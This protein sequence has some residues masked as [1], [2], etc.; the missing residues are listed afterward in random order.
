MA[1]KGQKKKKG[2]QAG[3]KRLFIL[4]AGLFLTFSALIYV[5]RLPPKDII[6]HPSKDSSRKHTLTY[7]EEIKSPFEQKIKLIDLVI[8]T[9]LIESHI[10][11][12][13][14]AVTNI[15]HKVKRGR[16][17]FEQH[18]EIR[19]EKPKIATFLKIL[20]EKNKKLFLEKNI[21]IKIGLQQISVYIDNILTH[22]IWIYPKNKISEKTRHGNL[23]LIIDDMG[24]DYVAAQELI[25]LFGSKI[26]LAILPYSPYAKKIQKLC[27]EHNV[28]MLLH[29]PMEPKSY[30]EYN[31][32]PGA[33]FTSMS[34]QQIRKLTNK[35]INSLKNIVAVNNH[36]GSKFT[37]NLHVMTIFLKELKKKNL[38]FIDSRTTPNSVSKVLGKEMGIVVLQRDIFLDNS[39][40][41][42]DIVLQLRKAEGYSVKK[43]YVIAIG[44][45]YPETIEA[46]KIWLKTKN[47][48][49][50]LLSISKLKSLR[51]ALK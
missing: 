7:E 34:D 26:N 37:E 22:L 32:G 50:D 14:F 42:K 29:M 1:K 47:P 18:I 5:L 16:S 2:Q 4:F 10:D 45:P 13:E 27:L 20:L 46:L 6:K 28:S 24:R 35:A 48:N 25:K 39:K 19:S 44:H 49:V 51:F 40:N 11:S 36:M 38:F 17:F 15:Y 9:A 3:V 30:P 43:D 41:I 21:E 23:I 33:L 31:P 12:N 8:F